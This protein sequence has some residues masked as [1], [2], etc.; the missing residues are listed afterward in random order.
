MCF[1]I[2]RQSRGDVKSLTK[3]LDRLS[4]W[5]LKSQRIT[6]GDMAHT[7]VSSDENSL[8]KTAEGFGGL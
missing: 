4:M 5:M 3:I 7:D 1:V 8:R 2:P 6:V